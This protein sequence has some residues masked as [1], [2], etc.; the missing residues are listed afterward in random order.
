M[1]CKESVKLYKK[2]NEKL[3]KVSSLGNK[4]ADF[5]VENGILKVSIDR[6]SNKNLRFKKLM[7]NIQNPNLDD[8]HLSSG[9]IFKTKKLP[10]PENFIACSSTIKSSSFWT[11]LNFKTLSLL[12]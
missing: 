3:I 9:S 5:Y 4:E 6:G 10:F 1:D 12:G 11:N 2:A 8:I 7:I